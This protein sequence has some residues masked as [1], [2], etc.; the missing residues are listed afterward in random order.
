MPFFLF[1]YGFSFSSK[2]PNGIAIA[3]KM[4][5]YDTETQRLKLYAIDLK[6]YYAELFCA[7][8]KL[9]IVG[10]CLKDAYS[11]Y[12]SPYLYA[13]DLSEFDKTVYSKR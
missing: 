13:I 11:I 4:Q 12:P 10:G 7:D 2:N 1:C 9:Y 3:D 6:L 5:V 8:E